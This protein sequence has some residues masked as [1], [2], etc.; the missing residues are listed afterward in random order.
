MTAGLLK[1]MAHDILVTNSVNNTSK[2]NDTLLRTKMF[3]YL[4][5]E[6]E[7]SYLCQREKKTT[8]KEYIYDFSSPNLTEQQQA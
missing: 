2:I 3:I 7:E 6:S 4:I 5:E 8:R 1:G